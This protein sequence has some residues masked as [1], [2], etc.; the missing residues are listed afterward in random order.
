MVLS[1][2]SVIKYFLDY[3]LDAEHFTDKVLIKI[4][5]V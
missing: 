4:S 1:S 2:I 3:F 5:R